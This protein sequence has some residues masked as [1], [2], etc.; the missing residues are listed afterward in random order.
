MLALK[1]TGERP[2]LR[3]LVDRADSAQLREV[4][5]YVIRKLVEGG[6]DPHLAPV[7]DTLDGFAADTVVPLTAKQ[8]LDALDK[9]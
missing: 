1:R 8:A 5:H 7:L 9:L 2:L 4:A 3:T 6:L